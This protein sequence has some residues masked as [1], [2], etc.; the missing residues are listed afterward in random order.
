MTANVLRDANTLPALDAIV[1]NGLLANLDRLTDILVRPFNARGKRAERIRLAGRAAID[2]DF[3]RLLE[4]MG[5]K[6]AADL[7]ARLVEAAARPVSRSRNGA[8][9]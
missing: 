7:G 2:F 9:Q 6:E 3:W 8:Q 5:D 1:S 4:P